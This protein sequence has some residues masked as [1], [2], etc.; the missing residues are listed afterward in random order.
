MFL[1]NKHRKPVAEVGGRLEMSQIPHHRKRS[2][3]SQ[4]RVLPLHRARGGEGDL[5]GSVNRWAHKMR[6]QRRENAGVAG[7]KTRLRRNAK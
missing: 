4:P 6:L 2:R 3:T 5:Q 1:R 7:N